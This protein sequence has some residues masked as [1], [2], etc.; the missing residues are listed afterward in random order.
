MGFLMNPLEAGVA[1]AKAPS[2]SPRTRLSHALADWT[3]ELALVAF[4]TAAGIWAQ[5]RWLDPTGDPGL[6]WSL[7]YRLAQG[8]RYYR[9]IFLQYGPLSPYV[10]ALTGPLFGFSASWLLIVNWVPAIAAGVLLLRASR[11]LLLL[12]ERFALLG[13][14]LGLSVFAPGAGRLV[15]SY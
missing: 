10:F 12:R 11:P 14:L 6:W 8:Q 5:G 1:R 3:P 4:T 7:G 15:F 13:F 9:D 2:S